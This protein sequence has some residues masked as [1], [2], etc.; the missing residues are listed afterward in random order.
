MNGPLPLSLTQV[1]S[2]DASGLEALIGAAKL[3]KKLGRP[4]LLAGLR[5]QPLA[6]AANAGALDAVGAAC[7]FP[8]LRAAELA[9][10]ALLP[11]SAATDSPPAALASRR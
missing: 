2:V 8:N 3:A 5:R 1:N 7:I 6:A 11:A 9:A 4:L 10:A